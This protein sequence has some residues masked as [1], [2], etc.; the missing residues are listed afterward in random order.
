[1]SYPHFGPKNTH[2]NFFSIFWYFSIH[3][4]F[5]RSLLTMLQLH[6]LL[7]LSL[8]F[9]HM[10]PSKLFFA[11]QVIRKFLNQLYIFL[12][13]ISNICIKSYKRVFWSFPTMEPILVPTFVSESFQFVCTNHWSKLYLKI[14]S[15]LH[16]SQFESF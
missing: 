10:R 4:V 6:I 9:L 7:F 2:S 16:L 1:M 14:I 3:C 12:H 8:I 5:L 11:L 13:F 15:A